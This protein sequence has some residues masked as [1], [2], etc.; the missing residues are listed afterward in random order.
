MKKAREEMTSTSNLISC[1]SS[2]F[3]LV[4]KSSGCNICWL[5]ELSVKYNANH[6]LQC[7]APKQIYRGFAHANIIKADVYT[8]KIIP[9]VFFVIANKI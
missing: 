7:F 1:L 4:N 5:R 2:M 3:S 9:K 8:A 6:S